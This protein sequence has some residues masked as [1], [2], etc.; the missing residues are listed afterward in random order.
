MLTNDELRI[1]E[2]ALRDGGLLRSLRWHDEPDRAII[3]HMV[4]DGHLED[5]AEQPNAYI[6]SESAIELYRR[7]TNRSTWHTRPID[8]IE[9]AATVTLAP[10]RYRWDGEGLRRI[11]E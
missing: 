7:Q 1:I 11:E 9:I 3:T 6:V 10:G 2:T 8:S 5:Y 4:A